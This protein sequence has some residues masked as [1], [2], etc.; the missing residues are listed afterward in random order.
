M[1]KDDTTIICKKPKIYSPHDKELFFNWLNGSGYIDTVVSTD[2]NICI[3]LAAHDLHD[4]DLEDLFALFCRYKLDMKPLQTFLKNENKK[5]LPNNRTVRWPNKVF[6]SKSGNY[7][8][9]KHIFFHS[10]QDKNTFFEWIERIPSIIHFEG[11]RDELYLD[12]CSTVISDEDLKDIIGLFYRYNIDMKQLQILLNDENKAWF[13]DNKKAFWHK[14]IF[15][16][17]NKQAK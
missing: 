15:G 16:P 5:W 2:N 10:L 12:L 17:I 7:L 8:V 4:H 6:C 11:A 1:I 3:E 14:R 9:C 13:Q